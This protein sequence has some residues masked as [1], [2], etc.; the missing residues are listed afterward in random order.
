M[1]RTKGKPSVELLYFDGCPNYERLLPRV[2]SLAS[3]YGLERNVVLRRVE[4]VDEAMDERFLGSPT[5]RV[6]GEDI[7]RAAKGRT[8]YGLKCRVYRTEQGLAGVPPEDWL[9][10]ALDEHGDAVRA[11]LSGSGV[12]PRPGR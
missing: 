8:D 1:L 3:E 2:R 9:R 4:S 6:D 10:T 11:E 5:I 7:E 12:R